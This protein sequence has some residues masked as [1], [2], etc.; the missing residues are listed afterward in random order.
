MLSGARIYHFFKD[1][2]IWCSVFAV[3]CS[4]V[5]VTSFLARS[6]CSPALAR[7]HQRHSNPDIWRITVL[8]QEQPFGIKIHR[9]FKRKDSYLALRFIALLK[10]IMQL[11]VDQIRWCVRVEQSFDAAQIGYIVWA[12]NNPLAFKSSATSTWRVVTWRFRFTVMLRWRLH[13]P[14]HQIHW[15][16][17]RGTNHLTARVTA[18]LTRRTVIW[19]SHLLLC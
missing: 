18:L 19:H 11:S 7:G 6:S 2:V 13:L 3:T 17:R 8:D 9:F 15:F 12:R 4:T 5:D 16:V 14:A 10:R 1:E